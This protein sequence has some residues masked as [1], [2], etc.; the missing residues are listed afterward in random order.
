MWVMKWHTLALHLS[1]IQLW[2]EQL[3]CVQSQYI[4]YI[5]T[6]LI[7]QHASRAAFR[8][9]YFHACPAAECFNLPYL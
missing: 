5:L 4:V 9:V 8:A 3:E 1:A 2:I 6:V 7:V